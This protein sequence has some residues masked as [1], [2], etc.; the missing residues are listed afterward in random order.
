MDKYLD[1]EAE[2]SNGRDNFDNNDIGDDDVWVADIP[3]TTSDDDATLQSPSP[4]HRL[5]TRGELAWKKKLVEWT[6]SMMVIP[7]E[8]TVQFT[9]D[10]LASTF[11]MTPSQEDVLAHSL[12]ATGTQIFPLSTL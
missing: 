9:T 3:M 1:V 2:S 7:E 6:L 11:P 8:A 4:K 10:L 12:S 5:M